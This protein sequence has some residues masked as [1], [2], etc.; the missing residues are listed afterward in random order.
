[1]RHGSLQRQFSTVALSRSGDL[2]ALLDLS[3]ELQQ[4]LINLVFQRRTETM[5]RS[6]IN[7]QRRALHDFRRK[8][9]RSSDWHNLVVISMDDEC[10]H[11]E[12]SEVFSVVGFRECLDALVG[13][14]VSAQHSLQ[15][16]RVTQ[17]LR[18]LGSRSVGA[19]KRRAQVFKEL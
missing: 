18:N 6:R 17:S 14:L 10:R 8:H 15:P 9:C 12:L 2:R 3:Q 16:E 4:F 11:V 13:G 19:I 7:F 1:M 5:W